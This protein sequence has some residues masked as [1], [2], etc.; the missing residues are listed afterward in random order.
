VAV[1]RAGVRFRQ[2]V[3]VLLVDEAGRVLLFSLPAARDGVVFWSGPGGGIEDGEDTMVA[4]RRIYEA[5]GLRDLVLEAEVWQ[6][7]GR[8]AR[9]A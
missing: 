2:A 9:A 7:P 4:A 1:V 3:R 8:S 6:A 5:T